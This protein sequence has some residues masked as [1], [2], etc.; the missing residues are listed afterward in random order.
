MPR[1]LEIG[2]VGS[3][4]L[5]LVLS[6][7]A[8]AAVSLTA[9]GTIKITDRLVKATHVGAG[10]HGRGAG[11]IDFYRQS[12]FNKGIRDTPIGHTD[13][14]CINTGTGSMN[15]NGTYFLP[16]GKIMVQGVVGSRLFYELAVVG[17]TGLYDNARGTVTVT[18]LGGPRPGEFLVFRLVI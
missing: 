17:G 6:V 18:Y 8:H 2:A 11:A 3:L 5:V 15:C 14:T 10:K 1:K 16:K 13:I 12:L 7:V 4:G 9:P